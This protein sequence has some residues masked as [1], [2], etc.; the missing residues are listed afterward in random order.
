MTKPSI[1]ITRNIPEAGITMLRGCA[2]IEVYP[3]DH[4]ASTQDIAAG[5]RNADAL[6][7]LLTDTIT[8][9]MMQQAPHLKVISN[10][11]VGYN[12]IDVAAAS[13]LGIAVT[14]T[15][16]VL[17]DATSDLAF[18]LL[19]SSARRIVESD[20]WL[21]VSE[22]TGWAPMLFTGQ[23]VTGATLGI[24]GGGR[25]GEAL[26][27]KAHLGFSMKILYCDPNQNQ[28]MEKELG[29]ERV[30]LHD[31]LGSADYVSLHTPYVPETH[32]MI[33]RDELHSMK[34]TAILINTSRGPVVDEAALIEALEQKVIAGAGLD[35][36]E[37]EPEVPSALRR[38]DNVV[39]VPHIGSA[40]VR[41]RE[42]MAIMAAENIIS[43]FRGT[44]PHSRIC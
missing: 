34:P 27:R 6:L 24:V 10:Y 14:N 33:G 16:G 41:T 36:F 7:C 37:H 26:A 19:I 1:Y 20:K 9:E 17:T 22:F 23:E 32:H 29:A 38:I 11:A 35:V 31:L 28:T 2:D 39:I 42:R 8:R 40:S 12:N 21:R 5:M 43:I 4:P 44:E 25:I 15:P 3:H 18:A 13:E 30:E